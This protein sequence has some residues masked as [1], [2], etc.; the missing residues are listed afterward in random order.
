[1][2]QQILRVLKVFGPYAV[3][4]LSSIVMAYFNQKVG[5]EIRAPTTVAEKIASCRLDYYG[6]GMPAFLA[7]DSVLKERAQSA[8]EVCNNLYLP[9]G[10]VLPKP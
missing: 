7:F 4:V 1:M 6:K 10:H 5:E 8:V 2:K 9:G 3:M